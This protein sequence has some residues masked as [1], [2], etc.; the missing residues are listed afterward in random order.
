MLCDH[1]KTCWPEGS[2]VLFSTQFLKLGS[3][4]FCVKTISWLCFVL[5]LAISCLDCWQ[6]ILKEIKS[7]FSFV[8]FHLTLW[9][10]FS[11]GYEH[12]K[13]MRADPTLC[14]LSRVGLS[15][16]MNDST[17]GE[18]TDPDD[19]QG[20]F[21]MHVSKSQQEATISFNWGLQKCGVYP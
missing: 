7:T 6:C 4:K 16:D 20:F 14:F 21:C 17:V 2:G 12:Y 5:Y 11:S 3:H 8:P 10:T 15:R 1:T 18:P 9:F 13:I 19:R